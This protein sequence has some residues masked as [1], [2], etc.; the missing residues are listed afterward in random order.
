MRSFQA[1]RSLF[2]FS[3]LLTGTLWCGVSCVP[4][5]NATPDDAGSQGNAAP[6]STLPK[7]PPNVL[8]TIF[9]DTFDRPEGGLP[10][11]GDLR[12]GK[13]P[14]LTGNTFPS[15]SDGGE[16][17]DAGGSRD[18]GA[19]N[20]LA[21]GA[22]SGA[23]GGEGGAPD[24]GGRFRR[25]IDTLP[26]GGLVLRMVP[27]EKPND[28]K[29]AEKFVDKTNIGPSWTQAQ[30]NA[31]RI[32]D[33][34]LCVENAHNHGIW[35]SRPIPVNA[36]I[37]FDAKSDSPE[38]DLKAEFWGDG[39][40]FAKGTSYND[41]TSYLAI[42][43][44][45]KNT[46]NVLA[47]LDEHKEDRKVVRIDKDSDDPRQRPVM[48]GQVYHVKIERNDAKTV[49]YY[50]DTLLMATFLDA[51]PL[52]G[53]GHDHFGF[54]DWEAKVCFDNVKITPLP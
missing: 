18:G 26:D 43:G 25:V 51:E 47:R 10:G 15:A 4:P 53:P 35:F 8:T 45:W 36:R 3:A 23:A 49:R 2:S 5:G 9:E 31:W 39:R 37:E 20:G 48:R 27:M 34:W 33:G 21:S 30:T 13:T 54:N 12:L 22:S 38:G 24:A 44:G 14:S 16:P 42:L 40:G 46:L 19:A 17:A 29:P 11:S 32:E 52:M 28:E 6:T 41:A 50:V 1:K 7:P